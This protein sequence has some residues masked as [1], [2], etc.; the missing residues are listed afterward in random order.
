MGSVGIEPGRLNAAMERL[1]SVFTDTLE[2]IVIRINGF[3]IDA[4]GPVPDGANIHVFDSLDAVRTYMDAH[5][6]RTMTDAERD[7]FGAYSEYIDTVSNYL[8]KV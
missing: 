8:N 7:D 2:D 6:N 1:N 5:R 4:R 3:V